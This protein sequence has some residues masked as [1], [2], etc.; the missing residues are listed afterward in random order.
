MCYHERI[1]FRERNYNIFN[2]N[3]YLIVLDLSACTKYPDVNVLSKNLEL[4]GK[5][6]F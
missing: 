4:R 2:I 1:L 5:N 3:I 6:D